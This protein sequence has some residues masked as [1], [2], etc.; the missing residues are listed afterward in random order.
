MKIVTK[1]TNNE[2]E[3]ALWQLFALIMAAL[4]CLVAMAPLI[5]RYRAVKCD[6]IYVDNTNQPQSN[7]S[8]ILTDYRRRYVRDVDDRAQCG[9]I[10]P[11]CIATTTVSTM[12]TASPITTTRST[13]S[14]VSVTRPVITTNPTT[15]RT[16]TPDP[17]ANLTKPY[18]SWRLPT[19]AVPIDYTL[20]VS[21][22]DCFNLT[23]PQSTITF[24]GQV[25]IRINIVTATT[26]LV[27]HAKNLNIT[28]AQLTAVG[29]GA[30]TVT[31]LPEYEMIYLSFPSIIAVGEVTLQIV[32]N[33]KINERD[34]TGFYRE[35]FWK[36]IDEIRYLIAANFQPIHARK[37]FPCFDEPN[38]IATF[39]LTLDHPQNSTVLSITDVDTQTPS[40]T[41]F[42]P[43]PTISPDSLS[44][45]I[46]PIDGFKSVTKTFSP[47]KVNIWVR[48]ELTGPA[49]ANLDR[50]FEL[51][52]KTLTFVQDY[53]NIANEDLPNKI[54][55]IGIPDLTLD[56][57]ASASRGLLTFREEILTTDASL[58]SAQEIQTTAKI[59]V[60]HILQPWF[61]TTDWWD[62]IWFDKSL[63]SFL[64]YKMIDANYPTFNLMEQ[65]PIREMVPLMMDDF[66]PSM[67]PI[68]N[69][70]LTNNEEILD[71]LSTHIY[72]KGA[73]LL[74]L[75]EYVVGNDTFQ[76]AV[77]SIFNETDVSNILNTFYSNLILPAALNTS[78]TA[79]DFFHSWLDERNY[80]IVTVDFFPSNGTEN[81]TTITFFQ[82]RYFGSF[83][84]DSSSLDPNYKWKIYMECDLGGSKD[85][86]IWNL[87]DNHAPKKI[88]FMFDS[89]T[90]T[91]EL[92]EEYL[93]I[94]CNKDFYSFQV[95]E[96]V[97]K[98]GDPHTL[99]Q[100]FE[101]VFRDSIFSSNDRANLLNDAFILPHG[102]EIVSYDQT[103]N[104][105]R[106]LFTP[107]GNYIPWSVFVWHWN[108]L[109]D[110]E[111][112]S[113]Y[114]YNFK[115]FAT[116]L[117]LAPF[118]FNIDSIVTNEANHED[119]LLHSMFFELLCRIQN[120]DALNK[121]TE[122]YQ[123]IPASYFYNSTGVTNVNADYLSTAI[124]YHMQN[125]NNMD[126][127]DHLWA[128]MTDNQYITAQQRNTILRALGASKETWRLKL[129]LETAFDAEADI[130]DTQEFFDLI[131]SMSQN[132]IGRDIVW[133]FYRHNYRTLLQRYGETN[134]LFN[135][136]IVNIVQS[137]ENEYY[138]FQM[139][140]FI[141]QYP[142]ASKSQQLAK[143]QILMNFEWI[144]D[145]MA[146]S[147]DDAISAGDKLN[148]KQ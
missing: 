142:S 10:P 84:L 35:Q 40:M 4:A 133:N 55:L 138:Y 75:M 37:A 79:E 41:T 39:T 7:N 91:F 52:E 58:N 103:I 121:A 45:A 93:W 139:V 43:T 16:T 32:Y 19:F 130:I 62:N 64:A 112:H 119:R 116:R 36:S 127:W 83:A 61:S 27:L 81:K 53:L 72:S 59:I 118:S 107:T 117:T 70:N 56:E 76:T 13:Q 74:R 100:A 123:L 14:T 71:Y 129:L 144:L 2:V 106:E 68:S 110:V 131:I 126:E 69:H 8:E 29:T 80:P 15:P 24:N 128:L 95:T 89:S 33:G 44:W 86:D 104:L 60:E 51:V 96:Y 113:K 108:Y 120:P 48:S 5:S 98:G 134:R 137:F 111:E 114:F 92:D 143:D 63:S 1:R 78:I 21:C 101:L 25:S 9:V 82:A 132:P 94:K 6:I 31:Y 65:F 85:G 140:N 88:N 54:D 105:A 28:E 141:N 99:W 26:F 124:Y 125:T 148:S 22:P 46:L 147:L 135:Q 20:R 90:E 30:A 145:G 3:L 122:L 12:P 17:W 34:Q 73:S 38:M 136:L 115:Q 146:E 87:T 66:K 109:V 47:T 49:D 50:T 57:K 18:D 11:M 97:Y 67:W 77:R 102:G 42:L 23:S